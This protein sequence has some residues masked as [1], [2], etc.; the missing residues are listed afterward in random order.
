MPVSFDPVTDMPVPVE[1]LSPETRERVQRAT[2][3]TVFF[4][5]VTIAVFHVTPIP[6]VVAPGEQH[7]GVQSALDGAFWC[8]YP[9]QTPPKIDWGPHN[10]DYQSGAIS[11]PTTID[12]KAIPS[13]AVAIE[14]KSGGGLWTI[15]AGGSG[16]AAELADKT[17][18]EF[19]FK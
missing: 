16:E 7:Y 1:Q 14:Y 3:R 2:Q 18:R 17:A 19:T 6:G 5:G 9:R 11:F 12:G 10:H 8:Y 4:K 15:I 13:T